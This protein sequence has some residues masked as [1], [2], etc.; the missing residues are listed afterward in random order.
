MFNDDWLTEYARVVYHKLRRPQSQTNVNMAWMDLNL[1]VMPQ[2][3][4][5]KRYI[6]KVLYIFLVLV[7]AL[8]SQLLSARVVFQ[9][10]QIQR[11]YYLF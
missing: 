11:R 3:K 7:A 5:C 9:Y 2:R 6:F 1:I 10:L 4:A 8:T